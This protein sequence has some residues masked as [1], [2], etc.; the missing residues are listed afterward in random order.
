MCVGLDLT[1]CRMVAREAVSPHWGCYS[2][3]RETNAVAL[4]EIGLLVSR[5]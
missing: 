4:R 3:E 1:L 2:R 5:C